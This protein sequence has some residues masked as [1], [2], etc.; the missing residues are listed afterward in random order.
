[1]PVT[2]P[3]NSAH[4]TFARLS[5]ISPIALKCDPRRCASNHDNLLA[6]P[7]PRVRCHLD[8]VVCETTKTRQAVATANSATNA[9]RGTAHTPFRR[10]N[11]V[12][13]VASLA[14]TQKRCSLLKLEL[15][16]LIPLTLLVAVCRHANALRHH[17]GVC[18]DGAP[19][20]IGR[21]GSNRAAERVVRV[22]HPILKTVLAISQLCDVAIHWNLVQI[23]RRVGFSIVVLK[24][25]CV[26]VGQNGCRRCITPL[27]NRCS[28]AVHHARPRK[29]VLYATWQCRL[30]NV[31]HNLWPEL[32]CLMHDSRSLIFRVGHARR[33]ALKASSRGQRTD[34]KGRH[35]LPKM[36]QICALRKCSVCALR[37]VIAKH[38]EL[39]GTLHR[40][41][42]RFVPEATVRLTLSA[43]AVWARQAFGL[44]LCLLTRTFA[45]CVIAVAWA[46]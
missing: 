26:A 15:V 44:R 22:Q 30:V 35:G 11:R 18:V 41:P 1:M 6:S 32:F 3:R 42:W 8:C 7:P 21:M 25:V 4:V 12:Q 37:G 23:V 17:C 36:W 38:R 43:H 33:K 40:L 28:V 39:Y 27:C 5:V 29:V 31:K 14:C 16:P 46:S 10:S 13:C 9:W 24:A 20:P 34:C 19:F 2:A 45:P